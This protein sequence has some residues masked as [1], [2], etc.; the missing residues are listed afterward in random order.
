MP[1]ILCTIYPAQPKGKAPSLTEIEHSDRIVKGP[2]IEGMAGLATNTLRLNWM[3]T[4][5]LMEPARLS[6]E[7]K[8]DNTRLALHEYPQPANT[9]QIRCLHSEYMLLEELNH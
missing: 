8:A 3:C 2:A 7:Y 4:S 5:A 6:N 1:H 9:L